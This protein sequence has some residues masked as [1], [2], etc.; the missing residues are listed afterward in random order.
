MRTKLQW[1]RRAAVATVATLLL[2]LGGFPFPILAYMAAI[3]GLRAMYC[4]WCILE[5]EKFQYTLQLH[6]WNQ[7]RHDLPAST[8]TRH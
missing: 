2:G 3:C 5:I 8:N 6:Y 4:L 7:H 1:H